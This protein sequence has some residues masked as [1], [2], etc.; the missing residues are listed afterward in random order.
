MRERPTT[1]RIVVT[2][3]PQQLLSGT[4]RKEIR[5]QRTEIRE[6]E[7]KR[8]INKEVKLPE[9]V[10]VKPLIFE[11]QKRV[12][13]SV[14]GQRV[15]L[16]LN[17]LTR[18]LTEVFVEQNDVAM[19]IWRVKPTSEH[20]PPNGRIREDFQLIYKIPPNAPAPEHFSTISR[21]PERIKTET[22]K[23]WWQFW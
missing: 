9:P 16:P 22:K 7:V 19:Y 21:E 12:E 23:P 2:K 20:I 3:S 17:D 14:K 13:I 5:R 11:N 8:I 10:P 15:T 18:N 6:A 1:R 4:T